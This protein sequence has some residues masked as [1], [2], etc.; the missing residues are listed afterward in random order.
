[1]AIVDPIDPDLRTLAMP[2]RG[3]LKTLASKLEEGTCVIFLG[4]GA[5]IDR[6]AP[7]LP[8]GEKLSS[9]LA[10][11]CDLEWH[12]YVPL[13]TTAFYYEFY[14]TRDLL[15]EFLKHRIGNPAVQPS[16]TIRKLVEI[17]VLLEGRGKQVFIVTTNY[18]RK[19]EEA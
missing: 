10:A 3:M 9:E 8:T 18:D 6:L 1:M 7:D 17:A 19:F 11:E 14:Y 2:Y 4:A 5:A 12:H 16:R 15:N 13:S